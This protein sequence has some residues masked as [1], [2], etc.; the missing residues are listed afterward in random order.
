MASSE[1]SHKCPPAGRA[2]GGAHWPWIPYYSA[3]DLLFPGP[4]PLVPGP[5]PRDPMGV[6]FPSIPL[7]LWSCGSPFVLSLIHI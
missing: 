1:G 2:Q 7:P 5:A 4:D 3:G 6:H